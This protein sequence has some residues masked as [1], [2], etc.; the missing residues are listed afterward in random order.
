MRVQG[1]GRKLVLDA[2][3]S[4]K[5]LVRVLI[6]GI[7]AIR[8][9]G[10]LDPQGKYMILDECPA[11]ECD[12][13]WR[14]IPILDLNLIRSLN[15]GPGEYFWCMRGCQRIWRIRRDGRAQFFGSLNF[16]SGE[17]LQPTGPPPPLKDEYASTASAR[18]TV[19]KAPKGEEC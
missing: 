11:A 9:R 1:D 14:P 16:S 6:S 18:R 15:P 13:G 7:A 4:A 3:C 2:A 10:A 12:C 5:L 8:S 17:V 19:P